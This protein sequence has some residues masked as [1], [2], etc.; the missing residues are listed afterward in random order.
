MKKPWFLIPSV[1]LTLTCLAVCW[2]GDHL[3][4][5][6][7]VLV[8]P[9][10]LLL[11][12]GFIALLALSIVRLVRR[13]AY[14]EFASIAV[15]TVLAVLVLFFPFRTAKVKLELKRYDAPRQEV[16]EMVRSGQ[17]QPYD[18][19]GNIRLPMGYQRLSADGE[20]FLYQNDGEG[21]VVGFW[22]FRGAP[23]GS[24]QLIWSSGGEELIRA[25]EHYIVSIEKLKDHWYYVV[26]D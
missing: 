4:S 1:L 3:W 13:R 25:N 14:A 21:Q 19:I 17:L 8:L 6:L 16:V 24:I 18:G 12:G 10:Y 9:L 23:D 7:W 15:L 11:F 20:V 26:T 22:I 5:R 2:Y